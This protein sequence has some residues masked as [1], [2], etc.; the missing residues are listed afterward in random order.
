LCGRGAASA[1]HRVGG[2][3]TAG[4]CTAAVAAEDRMSGDD[5]LRRARNRLHRAA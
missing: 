5:G 1:D 3:T 4:L 2:T